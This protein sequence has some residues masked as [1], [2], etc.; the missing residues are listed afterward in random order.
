MDSNESKPPYRMR[1]LRQRLRE[2]QVE[3]TS[4]VVGAD[5]SEKRECDPEV[6]SPVLFATDEAGA[7]RDTVLA[8]PP[9]G[10]NPF[11]GGFVLEEFIAPEVA[12]PDHFGQTDWSAF[13]GLRRGAIFFDLET[14]GLSG[15]DMIFMAGYLFFSGDRLCL[16]QEVARDRS[17]EA[18]LVESAR[19]RLEAFDTVVT[20]NGKSF[21]LP[22]L[23]RRLFYHGLPRL[24]RRRFHTVDLL[25]LARKQHRDLANCRLGTLETEVLGKPRRPDDLPGQEVPL[26]F[27]D[28]CASEDWSYLLPVV[29]HNRI[30]LTTLVA[31]WPLLEEPGPELSFGGG[32]LGSGSSEFVNEAPCVNVDASSGSSP[33]ETA[34]LSKAEV[35]S[36]PSSEIEVSRVEASKAETESSKAEKVRQACR[37]F[38]RSQR[39]GRS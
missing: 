25:H 35:R 26:R 24:K 10:W 39:S 21:D 22:A 32:S 37:Q 17:E 13:G 8:G 3:E 12:D 1:R 9:P 20:Y 4:E 30:D 29:Y 2:L 38:R 18:G 15:E 11:E 16:I 27:E 23:D 19:R 33:V 34:E 5:L 14:T 31:L 36:E 7:A 28:F 6:P